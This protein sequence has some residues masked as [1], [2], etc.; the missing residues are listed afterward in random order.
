MIADFYGSTASWRSCPS[1]PA[2]CLKNSVS[3]WLRPPRY[4]L[5]HLLPYH[6]S[7]INVMLPYLSLSLMAPQ[8]KRLGAA[9]ARHSGSDE[10][11]AVSQLLQRISLHLMRGNAALL[12]GRHPEDD[13]LNPELYGIE[14]TMMINCKEFNSSLG[15]LEVLTRIIGGTRRATCS[16][17]FWRSTRWP[18]PSCQSEQ[19][20]NDITRPTRYPIVFGQ[21]QPG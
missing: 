11:E 3:G 14:Q 17:S 10:R 13:F 1:S 5:L 20:I 8:L 16:S 4:L 21:L 19:K 15:G 9:L 6:K 12:T 7:F 2:S 18:L